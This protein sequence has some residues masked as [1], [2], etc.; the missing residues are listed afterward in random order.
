[1]HVINYKIVS[2]KVPRECETGPLLHDRVH[3]CN[4]DVKCLLA[5][6][7]TVALLKATA[8]TESVE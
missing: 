5:L 8:S 6:A 1:V 3:I 7:S 4:L 2:H